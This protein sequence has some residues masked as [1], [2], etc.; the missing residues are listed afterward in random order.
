MTAPID[1]TAAL[2]AQRSKPRG[3]EAEAHVSDLYDCNRKAWMRRN[4][5]E[6]PPF[7][8]QKQAQFAIGHGY[9]A[10]VGNT[11][12]DAGHDVEINRKL[13]AF[14][15]TGHPDIIDFTL[16][17]LIETKTTDKVNPNEFVSKHH[18]LQAAAYALAL[19]FKRAIVLVKYAGSFRGKFSH[20][21]VAYEVDP[22]EYRAT[23]ESR[24]AEILAVTGPGMPMPEPGP[25]D[26]ASYDLCVYCDYAQC[27]RNPNYVE[28][29]FEAV[30]AFAEFSE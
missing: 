27:E 19:G 22:E 16:P 2:Y 3:D 17:A 24:A 30:A 5:Y 26:L 21:E 23:I 12:R 14:G 18:A 4:G 1:L 6:K 8:R 29:A 15:L 11:L 9:E 10:E 7:T 13:E 28:P 20:E 25:F